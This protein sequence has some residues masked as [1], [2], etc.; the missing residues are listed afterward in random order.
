[1]EARIEKGRIRVQLKGEN[2]SA[3]DVESFE[4]IREQIMANIGSARPVEN[5]EDEMS[6]A[7]STVNFRK[8]RELGCKLSH[9]SHTRGVVA[10]LRTELE[11][12]EEECKRGVTAKADR[13]PIAYTFKKSPLGKHQV[14]GWRFLHSMDTPGLFGDVGSGKT[15][16][17][18]TWLDSLIKAGENVVA[19]VVCP[20]NLIN[21]VWLTDIAQF[22]DMTAASLREPKDFAVL[23][24][25]YDEKGDPDDRMERA[26]IRAQRRLDPEAKKK[27][28][29]RATKRHNKLLDVRFGQ[30]ADAYIINP[31]GIRTDVK[32]KR[33]I[34][35]CKR[36]R[37]EGKKI[38][39]VIDESSKLK[40][41][42]S[43][44]YKS[45]KRI[46]MY[47]SRCVIMTGTPSPNGLTDLW[48]QFDVLDNGKTL[49][50]NFVDFRHD[51][52]K[53]VVLRGVTWQ[54]KQ[55]RTHS[56]T[57]WAPRAGAAQ[58]VYRRLEPRVI[59]FR[60]QDCIDLPRKRFLIR[61]VEMNAEQR[62]VYE[63]MESR[64][65][66]EVEG[67]TV[68]AKVA[69]VKLIKLREITGGF[70][71]TDSG[72]EQQLGKDTPKMLELDTLLEQSIADKLGDEGPPNKALIWAQYQ[73]ECKTLVKRYQRLYG[74]RGLFG[75]I[76]SSAKDESIGRF[77][78]DPS[79]RLLVCHPASVGH[80]LNLTE[81]NFCFYYSL[82]HNFEEFYQSHARMARAGQ[83][84]LMTYF[85]LVSPGTIDEEL[86]D[87]LRSKKDLS[88]II[89]DG[90]RSRDDIFGR[91]E[92]GSQA[93]F[94]PSWGI[95][96]LQSAA[97]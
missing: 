92:K 72:A 90:R 31:E 27:A 87:A 21:H 62:D 43:R 6:C 82:S 56:A 28:K 17:V 50:P 45:L 59:R 35:L 4:R 64:L 83:K 71:F 11:H 67:E 52:C 36:L 9:D 58:Q 42:T 48:A 73:W 22:T 7:I 89:T 97:G 33:I 15:F 78:T 65:F 74:A 88:D 60:T 47:C 61:D 26:Q 3:L 38:V 29:K 93:E 14:D 70:V 84:R 66:A 25:D 20:I 85:F 86:L 18:S 54:D 13:S 55:G 79:C 12:Y 8:L 68:T 5:S 91:R 96:D 95:P 81:A 30:P 57:K 2:G 44:T 24:E 39:L 77:K 75:G 80:G 34:R 10:R 53:E 16:I 23:A 76:S 94:D 40:S 69:A 1:M 19:I 46:R 37:D 63:A 32:E 41:R 51:T 49:Q